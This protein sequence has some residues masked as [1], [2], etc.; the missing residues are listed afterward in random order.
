MLLAA[1]VTTNGTLK[2]I[3]AQRGSRA[4]ADSALAFARDRDAQPIQIGYGNNLSSYKTS[5]LG[6][7]VL[8][9]NGY[10]PLIDGQV[11]M[12]LQQIGVDGSTYWVRYLI[13]C[14]VA[15]WL[16]PKGEEPFALVGFYHEGPVFGIAFRQAFL[17]DYTI[18]QTTKDFDVWSCDHGRK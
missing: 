16:I 3:D 9:L 4:V 10:P 8:A 5:Q 6:R 14:R 12:E 11:L 17:E 15:R 7:T 1:S 2:M 18:T 13:G